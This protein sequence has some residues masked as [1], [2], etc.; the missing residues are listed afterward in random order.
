MAHGPDDDPERGLGRF[1][2]IMTDLPTDDRPFCLGP[3]GWTGWRQLV[4]DVSRLRPAV[5]THDAVCNLV[6]DRYGFAVTLL[7]AMTAGRTTVLPPSKADHAVAGVLRDYRAPLVLDQFE[8][9]GPGAPHPEPLALDGEIHVFTSGSTGAPQTHVKTW[10]NLAASGRVTSDLIS[11][12]G[13]APGQALIVG[14]TPHQHMYGL[15]ASIFAGLAHGHCLWNRP[16][17]YPADLAEAV[18]HAG[19]AGMAGVVL[20]TSPPHLKFLEEQ[21]T[22]LPLIRCVISAT[23]PL[24]RDLAARLDTPTRMVLEIYG[25]TETGSLGWRRSAETDIWTQGVAGRLHRADGCVIAD[26]PHLPAP[27]PLNDEIDV[28][29]DGQ[30]RLLGRKGDMLLV[31]GKR[32]SL[33][34]LNAALALFDQVEDAV[35][36]RGRQ[37]AQDE[38]TA[39]VVPNATG[40]QDAETIRRRLAA[41]MAAHA[42]PLFAPKRVR[43]VT[44]IE[45]S[46]TGKVSNSEIARLTHST[47][48]RSDD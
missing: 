28:L 25:S 18:A 27:V 7:A 29:P 33:S 38:L 5:I 47:P 21:I 20:V 19:Q 46:E 12:A 14:T 22:E 15:E 39:L 36:V 42:D 45:R 11:R 30:F 17:F 24:H 1:A 48:L 9:T 26:L 40:P 32:H 35:I 41:H 43:I 44:R 16:V 3:D 23:A 4:S 8:R 6:P 34:A 37:A 13:L 2:G 31:A 10:E